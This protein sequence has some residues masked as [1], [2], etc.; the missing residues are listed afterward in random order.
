VRHHSSLITI[1]IITLNIFLLNRCISKNENNGS[2]GGDSKFKE[3]AGSFSCMKCHRDIYNTHINTAH[4]RTSAIASEKNVMGSFKE[5]GNKFVFTNN[6][7]VAMEQR[8]GGLY[9]VAYINGVEKK[10]QRFDI[11]IGSG[12]KGQSYASWVGDKLVQM[13]ITYFTSANQWCNSPGYPDQIAFNRPITSRCLECHT[14][15]VETTSAKGVEPEAFDKNRIIFGIDCEKCHGP[16]AKHVAFQTQNPDEKKGKFIINPAAFTRQQILDLCALCHGGRLEKIKPS[17]EFTAGDKLT[18]YFRIDTVGRSVDAIDVHGNQFG[19]LQASKCFQMSTT[20]T[21]VTCHNSHENEK[22]NVALFSQRC[23]SC[24][25]NSHDAGMTCKMT[26]T[27]G[28]VINQN[29]TRCHMPEQ[30]SMAIAVLLQGNS[31]PVP[32][33]MHTH[34]IKI[35]P[36]ETKKVV[37]FLRKETATEQKN[38]K[39][40]TGAINNKKRE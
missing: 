38:V 15:F 35:Y 30:P 40:K 27:L 28:A 18:D 3:Y 1:L 26:S 12:T 5:A 25:N 8:A 9:Q 31:F 21:C 2:G 23:L 6:R 24:H 20:M 34:L 16:G 13:P 33:T 7:I 22:G 17:F 36:E 11:V 19:L 39:K 14:T 4:F 29:C 10:S 37:A 32:A